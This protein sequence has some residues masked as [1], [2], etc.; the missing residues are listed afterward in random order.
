MS[1]TMYFNVFHILQNECL[2]DIFIYFLLTSFAQMQTA[3]AQ[4]NGNGNGSVV[5]SGLLLLQSPSFKQ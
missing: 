2:Y 4:A 3:E 1:C 5:V